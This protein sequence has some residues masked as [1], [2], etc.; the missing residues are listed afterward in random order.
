M[1]QVTLAGAT[2]AIQAALAYAREKSLAPLAVAV[3]DA[4]GHVRASARED[5]GG[6]SGIDIAVAKARGALSFSMSSRTIG[7]IF[8]GNV[9]LCVTLAETLKGQMLPIPGA[10]LISDSKG[11]VIGAITVA[12]DSPDNDEAAATAGLA[13]LTS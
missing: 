8:S 3:L 11:R 2:A 1:E 13:A 6:H 12:G 9:A 10:V 4:G 7:E 5:G